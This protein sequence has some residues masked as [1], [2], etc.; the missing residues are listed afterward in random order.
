M[1]QLS[2]SFCKDVTS[3]AR[4]YGLGGVNITLVD[5]DISTVDQN[6]ALMGAENTQRKVAVGI[7]IVDTQI[8]SQCKRGIVGIAAVYAFQFPVRFS[9][10]AWN[11][12]KW[13]L[14]YA[15]TGD[16]TETSAKAESRDKTA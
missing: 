15:E 6:P 10:T 1:L 16:G 3:S 4:I 7:V 2:F 14:P 8:G 9:V 5:D 12:T 11:L 13:K